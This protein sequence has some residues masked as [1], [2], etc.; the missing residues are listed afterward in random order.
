MLEE[1]VVVIFAPPGKNAGAAIQSFGD[2][3]EVPIIHYSP[4]FQSDSPASFYINLYPHYSTINRIMFDIVQYYK[5]NEFAILYES[6]DG[7]FAILP[8]SLKL[9]A[10]LLNIRFGSF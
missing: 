8:C 2:I 5:W 10:I 9:I 6:E 3:F 1:G 4:Q 7:S